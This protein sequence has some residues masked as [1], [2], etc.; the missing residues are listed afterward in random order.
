MFPLSFV[1][2]ICASSHDQMTS[3]TLYNDTVILLAVYNLVINQV[4]A[5]VL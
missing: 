4:Q 5:A 1:T 2:M 3:C